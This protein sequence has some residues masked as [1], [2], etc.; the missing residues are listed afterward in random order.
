MTMVGMC[1]AF[2]VA[3]VTPLFLTTNFAIIAADLN[4]LN[5]VLWVLVAPFIAAGAIAP[6]VG[7]LSD[8]FGR[9]GIVLFSLALVVVSDVLQG[10]A[11][12]LACFIVGILMA[13]FAI[14]I[15]LLSIIAAATELVPVSR[16]GA[17]IGYLAMGLL[18]FAPA[19]FYGEE[20]A[21]H[22]WRYTYVFLGGTALLSLIVLA[23]FY[24]PPQPT[25]S[26]G[27][28]KWSLIKRLDF[29]GSILSVAGIVMVLI[30]INWGGQDY[31]WNSAQ[32]ISFIV[33]GGVILIFCGVYEKW[34][35]KEPMFPARL[36]SR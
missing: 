34:I 5:N 28:S 4:A 12:N 27:Q 13:G 33:V 25:K 11:P 23:I 9:R 7:S 15:Q 17:T 14:G 19:P 29:G 24:H 21:S 10:A 18:P 31:P 8:I 1:L 35:V 6:F 20:I 26:R 16:R 22:N 32:V 30:G 2:V 3:E 36:I